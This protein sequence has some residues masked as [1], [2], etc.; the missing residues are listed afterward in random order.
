MKKSIRT[1]IAILGIT[2]GIVF[3]ILPGSI[4]FLIG[5]LMLLSMDYPM[6]RKW[7]KV[8]QNNLSRAARS[9]DRALLRRKLR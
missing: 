7:L 3:A 9:L 4:L 8:S 2:I 1:F 6:A 5:G